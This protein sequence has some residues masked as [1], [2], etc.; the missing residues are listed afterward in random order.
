MSM[1]KQGYWVHPNR[2]LSSSADIMVKGGKRDSKTLRWV[3][4]G[5]GRGR[6]LIT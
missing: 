4:G 3:L 1:C 2:T 5:G 6:G